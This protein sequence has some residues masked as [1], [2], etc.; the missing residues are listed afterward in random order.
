MTRQE[1]AKVNCS[2]PV[3][4]VLSEY[5][6]SALAVHVPVTCKDPVTGAVAQPAPINIIFRFPLTLRQDAMTF[7]VPTTL[8]PQPVTFEQDAPAP[9]V[10]LEL[11]PVPNAPALELPAVPTAPPLPLLPPL[12]DDRP[13]HATAIIPSAIAIA[14]AADWTF[15]AP[16]PSGDTSVAATGFARVD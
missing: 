2:S 3:V 5:V 14:K 9:P 13:E 1:G 11:P 8:P 7:Q 4:V 15:I 6:P 16:T 10:P 12:P